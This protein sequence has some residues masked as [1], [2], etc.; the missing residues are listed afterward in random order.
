[1]KKIDERFQTCRELERLVRMNHHTVHPR[2]PTSRRTGRYAVD[3]VLLWCQDTT[4]MVLA[5]DLLPKST[6]GVKQS[7]LSLL[8]V[9]GV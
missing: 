3:R 1:M 6:G 5:S 2:D 4:E 9:A 8:S 7:T